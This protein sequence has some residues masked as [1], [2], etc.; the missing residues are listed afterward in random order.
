MCSVDLIVGRA[1]SPSNPSITTDGQDARPPA[2]P[3][4]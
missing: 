3:H 2:T 1:S 4:A